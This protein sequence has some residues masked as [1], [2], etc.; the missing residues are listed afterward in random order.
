MS[1]LV[2][3]PEYRFSLAAQMI[4]HC[5]SVMSLVIDL[6]F[7]SITQAVENMVDRRFYIQYNGLMPDPVY[8][9]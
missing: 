3:N 9:L 5:L 1:D 2:G 8:L 4:T 6:K 7:T